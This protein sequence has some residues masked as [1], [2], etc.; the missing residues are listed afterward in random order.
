MKNLTI[1]LFFIFLGCSQTKTVLICGDH[2]CI[3]KK[4]AKQY[5]EE[6]LSL[7]VKI[8]D[9]TNKNEQ[10]LIQLNLKNKENKKSITLK[11]KEKTEKE[12]KTLSNKEIKEIKN[13]IANKDMI[14]KRKKKKDKKLKVKSDERKSNSERNYKKIDENLF[15]VVDVCTILE[16]CSIEEISKFLIDQGKN[17]KYPDITL[18]ERKL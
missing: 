7:E 13:K 17:R 14:E 11:K 15:E 9:R 12:I 5:F 3:N 8:Q 4:E 1:F 10:D 18:R 6:N 16:N 2:I